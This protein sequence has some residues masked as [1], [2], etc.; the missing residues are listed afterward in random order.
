MTHLLRMSIVLA[1]CA[2]PLAL[3][4]CASGQHA[5]T[6]APEAAATSGG[7]SEA[8]ADRDHH[9]GDGVPHV[10]R[11]LADGSRVFG[12]EP[13]AATPVTPLPELL[14]HPSTYAGRTVKT[15]GQVAQVCQHMGCWMELRA[16]AGGQVV[17][18]PMAGHSFFLPRDI[19]GRQATVEGTVDTHAVGDAEQAH[20]AS[21]GGAAH[22]GSLQIEA[23]GVVVH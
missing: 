17:H 4:G 13:A 14:A 11:T 9:E 20:V 5:S 1:L 23:S 19:A 15:E 18:V 8:E 12:T 16:Q 3:I 22:A 21:E 10:T 2:S 6:A 7:A